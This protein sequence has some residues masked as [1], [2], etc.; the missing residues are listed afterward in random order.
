MAHFVSRHTIYYWLHFVTTSASKSRDFRHLTRSRGRSRTVTLATSL[1][2]ALVSL[3]VDRPAS[4]STHTSPLWVVRPH[5]PAWTPGTQS[6]PRRDGALKTSRPIV[7]RRRRVGDC[8]ASIVVGADLP[9]LPDAGSRDTV[10]GSGSTRHP[11]LTCPSVGEFASFGPSASGRVVSAAWAVSTVCD[12]T[13]PASAEPTPST[14]DRHSAWV[15][16]CDGVSRPIGPSR[17]R[18]AKEQDFMRAYR[19]TRHYG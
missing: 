15:A 1:G 12:D 16:R 7:P 5:P 11:H 18:D 3:S 14:V 17:P 19:S 13:K 9:I 4:V 2:P 10:P 6:G 8:S